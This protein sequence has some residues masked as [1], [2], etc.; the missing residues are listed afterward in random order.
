MEWTN[1]W[2]SRMKKRGNN[3]KTTSREKESRKEAKPT[4]NIMCL[5]S[6]FSQCF[7]NFSPKH[8][9]LAWTRSWMSGIFAYWTCCVCVCVYISF[10]WSIDVCI[11]HLFSEFIV[12]ALATVHCVAS[13]SMVCSFAHTTRLRIYQI[14]GIS[15]PFLYALDVLWMLSVICARLY[16]NRQ[17]VLRLNTHTN[18]HSER[19]T[20]IEWERVR[21][22]EIEWD[23]VRKIKTHSGFRYQIRRIYTSMDACAT[24][25]YVL[26]SRV[27]FINGFFFSF[28]SFWLLGVCSFTSHTQIHNFLW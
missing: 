18:I 21:E 2:E 24:L 28:F 27:D 6:S 11:W 14:F 22:S 20:F 16:E 19:H 9:D 12:P 13:V 26:F 25:A 5:L 1:K 10:V 8:F 23:R 7:S 3:E 17:M 4:A 15:D